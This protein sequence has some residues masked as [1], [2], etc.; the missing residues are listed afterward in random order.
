M[1]NIMLRALL[2]TADVLKYLVAFLTKIV[3]KED[4]EYNP[5]HYKR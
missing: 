5:W 4:S 2:N 1:G 3:M